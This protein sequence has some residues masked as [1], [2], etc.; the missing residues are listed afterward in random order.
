MLKKLFGL[1]LS[2]STVRKELLAGLT[3]FLTMAYILAVNPVILSDAGMDQGAV[4]TATALS[5]AIATFLIAF[6][7]K[8]PLAQAPSMGINA[9]F[10]YTLVGAMGYSWQTAL[11]ITFIEGIIF[12]L[13]S[14]FNIR[15]KIV[16]AIP[17][18]LRSAIPVGIGLFI[19]FIGLKSAGII[20]PNDATFVQLGAISPATLIAFGGILLSGILMHRKVTGALFY[21][22]V[23][24]TVVALFVGEVS[25]PENFSVVSMPSSLEP[26][27][28]QF[29]FASLL[30]IDLIIMTLLLVFMDIFNTLGTLVGAASQ[31]GLIGKDG[32]I[33]RAKEV[34]VS[35]AVGTTIGAALGT[36]TVTTFAES[37]AGIA[38][39][40]RSGLTAFVVGVLFL[41]ALFFSPI[42]LVIPSIATAGALVSVGVMMISSIKDIDFSD[43][44]EAMPS[45]LLM[46]FMLLTYSI[47]E[48]IALGIIIYIVMKL[49]SRD[50]RKITVFQYFLLALLI[51]RYCYL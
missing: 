51:V 11:T 29:D 24:C 10:A 39:G 22:I 6:V 23:I 36:S 40:G 4:F 7:A 31:A 45:F 13:L 38:E 25:L 17:Q 12:I 37:S 19:A 33:P 49:F 18:S 26:T 15:E 47:A 34:M 8:M 42:F 44:S 30:N 43:I 50:W 32:K 9:F 41:L 27:F 3:T 46:L 5:A 48:G 28:L 20:T 35:D 16:E 1:D 14:V 21:S 2:V